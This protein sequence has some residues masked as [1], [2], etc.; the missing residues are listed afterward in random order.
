MHVPPYIRNGALIGISF[1]QEI[2]FPT[3]GLDTVPGRQAP[4]HG[5]RMAVICTLQNCALIERGNWIV[6][7]QA[8]LFPSVWT[9][10][11]DAGDAEGGIEM[12]SSMLLVREF[13]RVFSPETA[14]HTRIVILDLPF[15]NKWSL[16][17]I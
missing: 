9:F 4:R 16:P 17:S 8:I 5:F 6:K 2:E 12:N 13:C 15:N 14:S 10:L 11:A 3:A 7:G 1:E